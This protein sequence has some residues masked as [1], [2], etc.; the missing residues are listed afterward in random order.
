MICKLCVAYN[1]LL[2]RHHPCYLTE[3]GKLQ[4][5]MP[6]SGWLSLAVNLS[7]V[8]ITII[9]HRYVAEMPQVGHAVHLP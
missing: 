2:V 4:K 6:N 3:A 5:Q 9:I 1:S 7:V 8:S